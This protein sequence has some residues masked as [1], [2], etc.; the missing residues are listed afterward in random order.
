MT[1]LP[2]TWNPVPDPTG[3]LHTLPKSAAAI[4]CSGV[5]TDNCPIAP[6]DI[7]TASGFAHC[8]WIAADLCPSAMSIWD[9]S[10]QPDWFANAGVDCAYISRMWEEEA[11]EEERRLAAVT[12]IC[13]GIDR[14]CA[15]AAWDVG[16]G[17]WGVI[18]GYD[19]VSAHFEVLR[20]DGSV[21][22]LP[23]DRL[24]RLDIPILSVLT[25]YAFR[26][27]SADRLLRDT[28]HLAAA[29]LRG[30][31]WSSG[32]ASGLAA[33]PALIACVES[34][35]YDSTWNLDY[36]LGTYAALKS[37]AAAFYEKHSA[38]IPSCKPLAKE[39]RIIAD[40]WLT[41]FRDNRSDGHPTEKHHAVAALLRTA[42]AAEAR[43]LA[44]MEAL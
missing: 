8:M 33:Y 19:D 10:M 15:S 28:V 41:A 44:V 30:E 25:P 27:K 42:H 22:T 26:P 37:H 21:T 40:A 14:R 2:I 12:Q 23:Y 31:E 1:S 9:F 6:E 7:V 38:D 34:G 18:R 20:P 35:M 36:Y 13:R 39:Y 16:G 17:E 29:H 4:L 11:Y 32:N 3:Y 24:G 43:A 5:F